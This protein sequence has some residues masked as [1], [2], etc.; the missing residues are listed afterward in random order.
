M[1]DSTTNVFQGLAVEA[2]SSFIID[3]L[4]DVYGDITG[5]AT[6]A[7]VD[8]L[9]SLICGSSANAD[10]AMLNQISA[11]LSSIEQAITNLPAAVDS[12]SK[13][14]GAISAANEK[15]TNLSQNLSSNALMDSQWMSF[16]DFLT[17]GSTTED[18][19]RSLMNA[20]LLG[21]YGTSLAQLSGT[22]TFGIDSTAYANY[23]NN[24]SY[25]NQSA[26]GFSSFI[27]ANSQILLTVEA[28]CSSVASLAQAAYSKLQ[29]VSQNSVAFAAL[30]P[31]TRTAISEI[32]T[33]ATIIAD[34]VSPPGSIAPAPIYTALMNTLNS[35]LLSYYCGNSLAVY[36]KLKNTGTATIQCIGNSQYLTRGEPKGANLMNSIAGTCDYWTTA[37]SGTAYNCVIQYTTDFSVTDASYISGGDVGK[38]Y[39]GSGLNMTPVNSTEFV[40]DSVTK[41]WQI[42][43]APVNNTTAKTATFNFVIQGINDPGSNTLYNNGG[44]P[45]T[46]NFRESDPSFLWLIQ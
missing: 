25:L 5:G 19:Y 40:G 9:W 11:Q 44:S 24:N 1:A 2:N 13:Y 22:P 33:N 14:Q 30:L 45:D 38:L 43:L 42:L 46:S 39:I 26:F 21:A 37:F 3:L 6:S 4:K 27:R 8:F 36:M 7:A 16:V 20:I 12:Y 28:S 18:D 31:D 15:V 10:A 17:P 41:A 23:L 34:L 35:S 29:A 32:V